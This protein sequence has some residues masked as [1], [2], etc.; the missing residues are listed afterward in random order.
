MLRPH[1]QSL[2]HTQY[3]L[4]KIFH[5]CSAA[6]EDNEDMEID[7]AVA[8]AMGFS[9][10]GSQPAKKR[11]FNPNYGFVDPTVPGTQQESKGKGANSTV[12]GVRIAKN[13][14][15]PIEKP[16]RTTSASG[17][18][19]AVAQAKKEEGAYATSGSA[20]NVSN[21]GTTVESSESSLEALRHGVR[22]EN[23]DMVY[24]LCVSFV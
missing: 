5:L 3:V 7:P 15:T 6:M 9:S 8:A 21:A 19:A 18:D 14:A 16:D 20:M 10:F 1:L 23:G 2:Q 12:L 22:N 24:F 11:K 17:G 4:L 13:A